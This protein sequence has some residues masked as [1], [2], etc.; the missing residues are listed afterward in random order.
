[1]KSGS[2]VARRAQHNHGQAPD[3]ELAL[4]SSVSLDACS[5]ECAAGEAFALG[6]RVAWP[7]QAVNL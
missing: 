3:R 5:V 1:M 2:K 4:L 6:V 7:F